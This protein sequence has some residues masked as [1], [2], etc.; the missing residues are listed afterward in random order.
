[1]SVE[2]FVPGHAAPASRL[3]FNRGASSL[4]NNVTASAPRNPWPTPNQGGGPVL[5][6]AATVSVASSVYVARC[7]WKWLMV[8]VD[9]FGVSETTRGRVEQR[10]RTFT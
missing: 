8:Y 5:S 10:A 4:R 6:A 7:P 2:F 9:L 3:F 1:M